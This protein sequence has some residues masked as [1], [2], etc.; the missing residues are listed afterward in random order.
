MKK[1]GV[2]MLFLLEVLFI[3]NK[4]DERDIF[5]IPPN[6]LNEGSLF[7][8]MLKGSVKDFSQIGLQTLG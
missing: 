4:R 2:T 3:L 8:G 7:G 5:L 1:H 6:F